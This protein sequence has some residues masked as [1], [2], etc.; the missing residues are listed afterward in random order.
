MCAS[1]YAS[2]HTTYNPKYKHDR[3]TSTRPAPD[4]YSYFVLS[5]Y[6]DSH[7]E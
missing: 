7:S 4:V 2:I 5:E 6:S 3:E 1:I